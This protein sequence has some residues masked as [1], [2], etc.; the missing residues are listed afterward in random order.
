[1]GPRTRLEAILHFG[2]LRENTRQRFMVRESRSA[3]DQA[4]KLRAYAKKVVSNTTLTGYTIWSENRNVIIYKQT[5]QHGAF[6]VT[7]Y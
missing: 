6:K 7:R 5:T 4:C 3:I 1:M 2:D